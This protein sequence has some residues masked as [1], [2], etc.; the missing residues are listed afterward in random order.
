MWIK[1]SGEYVNLNHI[2]RAKVS[3][4]F[5]N[6]TEEFVVELE[7]VIKGELTFFTRYRGVDAD[8]LLHA[9]NIHSQIAVVPPGPIPAPHEQAARNTLH[10]VRI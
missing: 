9:L 7:G 4:S 10:D 1:L 3:K 5:K 2:V 6:G 8:V